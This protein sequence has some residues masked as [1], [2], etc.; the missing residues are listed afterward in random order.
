MERT[1]LQLLSKDELIHLAA[2][3][4]DVSDFVAAALAW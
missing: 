2:P 4:E 3:E 1:D